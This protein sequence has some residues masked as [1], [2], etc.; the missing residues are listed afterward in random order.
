[1]ST[2]EQL[3]MYRTP[4]NVGFGALIRGAATQQTVQS[5]SNNFTLI[6]DAE[7]YWTP[8]GIHARK[9]EIEGILNVAG[10]NGGGKVWRYLNIQ[11]P[12][13]MFPP[14]LKL[15]GRLMRAR[16]CVYLRMTQWDVTNPQTSRFFWG[17][18]KLFDWFKEDT[19]ISWV[20][21]YAKATGGVWGNWFCKVSN[22]AKTLAY[23]Q[24]SGVSADQS[25]AS[26]RID[27][28][29]RE[30]QIR[31]YIKEQQVGIYTPTAGDIGGT[32]IQD[33]SL[34]RGLNI[35]YEVA[36]STNAIGE[37]LTNIMCDYS[38]FLT[39]VSEDVT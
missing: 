36:A 25:L 9:Y 16:E 20:C 22:D 13:F 3:R 24:D 23:D 17:H 26:L 12:T 11:N 8:P 19:G 4:A 38:G 35:G 21:F 37:A 29:G 15:D 5:Q 33:F 6:T 31:W 28:D 1:M 7:G 2:S 14:F 18:H 27:L 34:G 10:Q 32:S 30:G 39:E